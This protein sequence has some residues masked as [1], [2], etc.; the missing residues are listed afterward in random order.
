[1]TGGHTAA[2]VSVSWMLHQLAV[3]MAAADPV[4]ARRLGMNSTD[5]LAMKHLLSSDTPLGPAELAGLLGMSTGSTTA[6]IDRLETA[7]HLERRP[8]P[9]D[10]R[11]RVLVPSESAIDAVTRALQPLVARLDHLQRAFSAEEVAI[12]Q[13]FLALV[14]QAHDVFRRGGD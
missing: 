10:R 5:Y 3:S 11:R 12:I 6:L 4:I 9:G 13:R 2:R 14:G 1:M 8:H 7:G